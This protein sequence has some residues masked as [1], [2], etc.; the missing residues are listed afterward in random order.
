M[1]Q[2]QGHR[3]A[4]PDVGHSRRQRFL[5][6]FK[7]QQKAA[8]PAFEFAGIEWQK[9]HARPLPC[10]GGRDARVQAGPHAN[11]RL[12]PLAKS[13]AP[14]DFATADDFWRQYPWSPNE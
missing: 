3:L 4:P 10:C 8:L 5:E 2:L 1:A 6:Y 7:S 12:G 14:M 9:G 11:A 13:L